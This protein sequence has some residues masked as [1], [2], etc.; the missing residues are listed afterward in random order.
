M[1]LTVVR[2]DVPRLV[3]GVLYPVSRRLGVSRLP[4]SEPQA[5]RPGDAR[6]EFGQ[7]CAHSSDDPSPDAGID[8]AWFARCE[9]LDLVDPAREAKSR[10]G[11]RRAPANQFP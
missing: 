9:L 4:V 1:E 5:T 10:F 3:P 2:L 11:S 7:Q 8:R 6:L